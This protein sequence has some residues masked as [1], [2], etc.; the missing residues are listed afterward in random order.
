MPR[1]SELTAP[2]RVDL[3]VAG[4]LLI[5][6]LPDVPWW[7]EH[8][9]HAAPTLAVPGALAL[10]L[11]MSVPFWWRRRYP[12]PV[13]AAAAAVLGIRAAIDHDLHSAFAAVLAGC[14]G[15]GAYGTTV[16]R[17]A[18]WLGWL[19]L[20]AAAGVVITQNGN[21]LAAVP[22]A[23]L[24]AAFMLGDATSARRGETAASVEAAHQ[25]ERTRIARELH[26]VV[27]H[28]LSAIAVQAGAARMAGTNRPGEVLATIEQLSREAI[29]ELNHLLGALRREP[30]ADPARV[31]A[32]SLAELD[33]LLSAGLAAGV[34]VQAAAEGRVRPLSP[35]AEL[36]ACRIITEALANVAKHAPAAPTRV[37]LRYEADQLSIEVVNAPPPG[38]GRPAFLPAPAG[39]R[40]RG[41]QGMRERAEL[42][43]GWFTAGV[44][45]DGGFAVNAVIP[46]EGP[47]AAAAPPA[48]A[49]LPAAAPPAAARPAAGADAAGGD[50]AA[51]ASAD[52]GAP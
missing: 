17:Y 10:T 46:Y 6:G 2:R 51:R 4:V 33:E 42:Y 49:A 38:G 47:A 15:I 22:F 3:L 37:T 23:L 43:G 8:P 32:P 20:I 14:Y 5:W 9:G 28:Q 48:A 31:P 18:R 36:S 16:R 44:T 1:W 35:G 52:A 39:R 29:A 34:P 30:D 7:W 27:A 25:A 45:P 26:D 41:L 40:G 12:V 19:A 24:G 11:V 50:A 13:L 21:R